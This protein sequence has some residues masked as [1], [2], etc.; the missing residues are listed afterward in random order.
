MQHKLL[1]VCHRDSCS[2]LSHFHFFAINIQRSVIAV[3]IA[4][5]RVMCQST[6]CF[7]YSLPLENLNHEHICFPHAWSQEISE[8]PLVN[9]AGIRV[10][11]SVLCT[12]Y[13]CNLW[14]HTSIIMVLLVSLPVF[15]LPVLAIVVK[16]LLWSEVAAS[17]LPHLSSL[18][19]GLSDDNDSPPL[20]ATC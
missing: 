7:F 15:F 5:Q 20:F 4:Q 6:V 10:L 18:P 1:H 12:F 17:P 3:V 13:L 16:S 11:Y 2:R 14:D 19:Y 8:Q 9:P